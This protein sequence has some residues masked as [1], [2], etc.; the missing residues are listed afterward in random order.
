M[1]TYVHLHIRG[2]VFSYKGIFLSTGTAGQAGQS[3][4]SCGFCRPACP[5]RCP[6]LS[7]RPAYSAP[8]GSET[9][10]LLPLMPL[11]RTLPGLVAPGM[12]ER[13]VGQL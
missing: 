12:R 5:S 13:T 2:G 11:K 3:E 7:S 10:L 9:A 6:A 8:I 4:C 1:G